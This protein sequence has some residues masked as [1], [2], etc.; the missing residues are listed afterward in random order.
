MARW[1]TDFN[2]IPPTPLHLPSW[3]IDLSKH[4]GGR[5]EGV[6]SVAS[7]PMSLGEWPVFLDCSL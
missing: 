1:Q 2:F 5:V 7:T 4:G 3:H 6:F